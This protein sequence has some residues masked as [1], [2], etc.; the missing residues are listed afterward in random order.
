MKKILFLSI[1]TVLTSLA[2]TAQNFN[3]STTS[4]TV[5]CTTGGTLFDSGGSAGNYTANQN[6]VFTICPGAPG[7]GVFA[8]MNLMNI[9]NGDILNI[10]NGNSTAAPL[11]PDMPLDAN[12][13]YA[14]GAQFQAT[15]GNAS[16][17][18]TFEFI[19]NGDANVGSFAFGLTC[20]ARCQQFNSHLSASIPDTTSTPTDTYIDVCLG[21]TVFVTA[22]NDYPENNV[23]YPQSNATSRFLWYWDVTTLDID[24]GIS[25]SNYY[26]APGGYV[27]K[28][29][30]F[31]VNGCRN[32][33]DQIFKVRVAPIPEFVPLLDTIF[34]LGESDTLTGLP[35]G[36]II[37]GQIVQ[38]DTVYF[39]PPFYS[40]DS[41]FLPD[42]NGAVYTSP[43]QLTGFDL[44]D[45]IRNCGDILDICVT[46]EH[47]YLGDLGI[48]LVC[49]NGQFVTLKAYPGGGGTYLGN[50]YDNGTQGLG[51]GGGLEY[52]FSSTSTS[53]LLVNGPT[54]AATL[55][56]GQTVVP[57]TYQPVTPFTNLIGCPINGLWQLQIQDN[58]TI[59]DG[60]IFNW[61]LNI[62]PC[63]Y[64]EVDSF[65]MV[66]D[67]GYW[68]PNP[69]IVDT[70][71]SSNTII[72]QP[73][74]VGPQSYTYHTTNQFGC[75]YENTYDIFV[76]GFTVAATPA[77]TTVCSGLTV[78]LNANVVGTP[79]ACVYT[80]NLADSWGDGW[81]GNNLVARVNGVIVGTYTIA[82]GSSAVYTLSVPG[83]STLQLTYNNTGSFQNEVSYNVVLNGAIVHAAGPT[84]PAGI[85]FTNTCGGA[86][87]YIWSPAT[88]LSNPNIQN[89]VCTL[90]GGGITYT[91]AVTSVATGCTYY[92]TVIVR[93]TASFQFAATG[94]DTICKGDTLQLNTT[95]GAISYA[96]TPNNGTI[97]DTTSGNPFVYPTTTTTYTV[98]ADSVGCSQF[99]NITIT[100]SNIKVINVLKTNATC[101]VANGSLI[102]FANGG[103]VTPLTFTLDNG[104]PQ[105]NGLFNNLYGG[106][107]SLTISDGSGCDFDTLITIGGG[108]P[109]IIDSIYSKN[110]S[111]IDDGVIQIF[112]TDTNLIV[113]YTNDSTG[114]AQG[115]NSFTGLA[116][117]TYNITIADGACPSIDT[118]ITLLQPSSL[119][120][121]I[122]SV[123]NVT[124]FGGTDGYIKISASGGSQ[125]Y[126]YT[127]DSV[128]FQP[129][130]VFNAL[131]SGVYTISVQDTSGCFG[132]V[133]VTITEPD[134]LQI[135]N[136]V[137][138]SAN[139]FGL[140][141]SINF[142]ALGGTAPYMYSIDGV[143]TFGNSNTFNVAAGN[144]TMQVRDAN[145]CLST[146][147][148]DTIFEPTDLVLTL[149]SSINASCG[150][151][152]GGVYVSLTGGTTPYTFSWSNG[153]AVVGGSEDLTNILAGIYTLTATDANGCF[154]QVSSQVFDNA[155]VTLSLVSN[156]SVS[157]FGANDATV[158]LDAN[159]GTEPYLFSVN[160]GAAQSD[161]IFTNVRGG[162]NTFLVTDTN[163]CT[164]SIQVVIFEPANLVSTNTAKDLTC[165]GL[166]NGQIVVTTN[167]GTA[168]YAYA[169]NTSVLPQLNGTF[170][171]LSTGT[172]TAYVA[173]SNGCLD[174]INNIVLDMPDTL[175]ITN[176][177]VVDVTCFGS[178]NGSLNVTATG[179]TL[180]YAYS[181]NGGTAQSTGLFSNLAGGIYNIS[182]T[183]SNNCPVATRIDTIASPTQIVLT[184]DSTKNVT[185]FGGSNGKIAFSATGGSAPYTYSINNGTS[186]STTNNYNN[187]TAGTY[188]LIIKDANNCTSSV[189]N[190]TITQP[191]ALAFTIKS[192]SVSCFGLADGSLQV[193]SLTGGTAPYTVSLN[194]AAAV[195][196]TNLLTL[197][198]LVAANNYNILVT[199]SNGCQVSGTFSV[200]QPAELV[201]AQSNQVNV[202]CFGLSDASIKFSAT[203]GTPAYSFMFD[204]AVLNSAN[205]SPVTYNNID[206]GTYPVYVF[207]NKLCSDTLLVTILEPN[208]IVID[209]IVI[210][211]E[212]SCFGAND[213][214]MIVYASGGSPNANYPYYTYLWTPSG[215]TTDKVSGLGA[216]V[217]T[218]TV[219]DANGCSTNASETIANVLPIIA[220]IVPDSSV[221]NM[222]DTLQLSV[223]IQNATGPLS[224]SWTPTNG[225]SCTDCENPFVTV[226]NDIVY[227]V[228]VTDANGCNNYNYTEALVYVNDSLFYFIP[229]SFTPN[230]DGIN[231]QFQIFGQDI[232]SVN[233]MIFNRWGEMI[234]QGSNQF[235]TWDGTYQ[236][237][238]QSPGVYTYSISLTFLNDATIQQNGSITL[239]R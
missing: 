41:T 33:Q 85:V 38:G 181:V 226:Y 158:V 133:T 94:T 136:L 180:P 139:C 170:N 144:Y 216:G 183:D 114:V 150:A 34:C 221:I 215:V 153:S 201:L 143:P 142:S 16:G 83:N 207:D 151:T 229:N 25:Q 99:A 223:N 101:G 188:N 19:S 169:L 224:Y 239:I 50:P 208:E 48:K 15:V 98:K 95:G 155:G 47:S 234:F 112:L 26:S 211:S 174:T 220:N 192:N 61:S 118:L 110:A 199:D 21:D 109:L 152:D 191:V 105:A 147:I 149:D 193:N 202:S 166:N 107:H 20:N 56:P 190:V 222:G 227:S 160:G 28:L 13:I 198:N 4:T 1:L 165:F 72:I 77:D 87:T 148:L 10:Y 145:N 7:F 176:V 138:D 24:S 182:V 64:P 121:S 163:G 103:V 97:S 68:D 185:C 235:Q 39:V 232:Q 172:Y 6:F 5:N 195:P 65:I 194:G 164:N 73:T 59:D 79:P 86:Y 71:G 116:G 131:D 128:N 3:M 123:K 9:A 60:Y 210:L 84:P 51:P 45:T 32:Y 80:F 57:G 162:L 43:A 27:A 236:G 171:S 76:N 186:Y 46:M 212:M 189:L 125:S 119:N 82:T 231:D 218:A 213:A 66:Y 90:T 18:L 29:V 120:L 127:L 238:D 187:L 14:L 89:P 55:E 204:G 167:G 108:A 62:A 53:G 217:Y 141:G 161:S 124:C 129:T 91:V 30:S 113:T 8:N 70:V 2:L 134:S 74:A 69:T 177:V 11:F 126:S 78:P 88:N 230:G 209:S 159:L 81:N 228:V 233:L 219:T 146:V 178:T 17:C 44:G 54:Q 200:T 22:S 154:E 111:C 104:T 35:A 100:V 96:W 106:T 37:N 63:M 140:L 117:G 203:G 42:G 115:T 36:L 23:E 75:T 184:L 156:D 130:G 225:L 214:A 135:T 67:F 196:Y 175:I 122:D 102:I 206:A 58:L 168:P 31:D 137:V 40:G 12:T 52:C 237:V 92:D 173:D 157:C 205:S 93:A 197:S 132:S 179:G 49:P